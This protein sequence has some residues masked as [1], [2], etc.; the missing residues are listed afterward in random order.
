M[1]IC[2]FL[3]IMVQSKPVNTN[4][5]CPYERDIRSVLI[6]Q[7]EFREDVRAMDKENCPLIMRSVR[8]KRVSVRR[9]SNVEV[10]TDEDELL[11]KT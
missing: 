3:S 9:G 4:R 2:L 6:K 8:N 10:T 1:L 11:D 5:K 7:V